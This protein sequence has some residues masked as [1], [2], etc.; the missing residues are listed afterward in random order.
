MVTARGVTAAI[1]LGLHLVRRL[2]GAA[3][4]LRIAR[5]MDYPHPPG[6]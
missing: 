3:A 2:A 6:D 1:D 5:Q 4:M